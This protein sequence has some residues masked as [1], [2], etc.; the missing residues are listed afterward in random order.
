MQIYKFE[1]LKCFIQSFIEVKQDGQIAST[2]MYM[3]M[4]TCVY[5]QKMYSSYTH[6]VQ[7]VGKPCLICIYIILISQGYGLYITCTCMNNCR[8]TKIHIIVQCIH[9]HVPRNN[10]NQCT[11]RKYASNRLS[12]NAVYHMYICSR[13]YTGN[14]HT[15]ESIQIMGHYY[16]GPGLNY[17]QEKHRK[18]LMYMQYNP[19]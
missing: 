14:V 8:C 12:V 11:V 6:Q 17:V 3:Y 16:T 9:V 15:V 1:K 7:I 13:T 2:F 19:S 4:T 10:I 5:L 18:I